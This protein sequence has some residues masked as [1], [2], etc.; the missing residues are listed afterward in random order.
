MLDEFIN[1]R[2]GQIDKDIPRH[3]IY[4]FFEKLENIIPKPDTEEEKERLEKELETYYE[5]EYDKNT[6]KT[7]DDR[8]IELYL[9]LAG[10]STFG[11][12]ATGKKKEDEIKKTLK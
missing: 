11:L 4:Y 1:F 12:I 9:F 10:L 7:G 6:P 2:N 5:R 8:N 3:D